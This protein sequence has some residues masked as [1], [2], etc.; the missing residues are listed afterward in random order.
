MLRKNLLRTAA[1]AALA[2][3]LLM[4]PAA[5]AQGLTSHPVAGERSGLLA[6]LVAFL[7]DLFPA[8][9]SLDN[10]CTIDPNGGM[11][12]GNTGAQLDTRCTID[13]DGRTSCTPDL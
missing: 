13:P 7:S 5:K 9:E 8:S 3:L 1:A 6:S 2:A 11:I 12:C 4:A 10:R